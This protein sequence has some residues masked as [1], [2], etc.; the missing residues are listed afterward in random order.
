MPCMI[1]G[2]SG[3]IAPA[4]FATSSAPPVVG[5]VL[6]PFPLDAEPVRVD[7]VEHAACERAEMLAATPAVDIGTADVRRR[8]L[9]D[10]GG[11]RHELDDADRIRGIDLGEVDVGMGRGRDLQCSFGC[12][13]GSVGH[14]RSLCT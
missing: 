2:A 6:E 1:D 10:R 8:G 3:G 14:R 9:R 12:A 7:R 11:D 4:W 5:K 13:L